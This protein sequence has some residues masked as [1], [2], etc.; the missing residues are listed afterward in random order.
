M[1]EAALVLEIEPSQ[2]PTVEVTPTEEVLHSLQ[3]AYEYLNFKLFKDELP[4]CILSFS[5]RGKSWGFFAPKRWSKTPS[6]ISHEIGLNPELL[7]R[8]DNR[9]IE[10]L[11]RQMVCLWQHE[12]G[13]PSRPGYVNAELAEKLESLGLIPSDTGEPG[14]KKTGYRVRHYLDPDGKF[15]AVLKD[16]THE[17]FPW[18]AN[19]L[20]TLEKVKPTRVKF[21]CPVCGANTW[22]GRELKLKCFTD[23]CNAD[24][25]A[26]PEQA[27]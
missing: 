23:N 13:I 10:V 4:A 26:E 6:I 14:G 15:T 1:T 16:I 8:G 24:M 2:P 20:F 12:N 18:K 3:L 5:A 27:F 9:I 17:H 7:Q 22:G 19:P 25:Q 21:T 11:L